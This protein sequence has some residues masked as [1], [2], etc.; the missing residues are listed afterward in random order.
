MWTNFLFILGLEEE[1]AVIIG[2]AESSVYQTFSASKLIDGQGLDG[3]WASLGC[4]HTAGGQNWFSLELRVPQ[5]ITRVKIVPRQPE[6]CIH[7][8]N[9]R[10]T[11]GPSTGYDPNEPLCLPEILE[12]VNNPGLQDYFC[13]GYLHE[14][15]FVKISRAGMLNLCEVKVFTQQ[16]NIR[17]LG[18]LSL[19]WAYHVLYMFNL[20][21]KHKTCLNG[22]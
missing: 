14:G 20:C 19:W 18:T 11:I 5:K 9:I 8:R 12:L 6:G 22:V 4:A 15:K 7:A 17:T 3:R 2:T 16:G 10:I 21:F 13:T 1:K